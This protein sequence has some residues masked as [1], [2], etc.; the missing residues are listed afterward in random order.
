MLEYGFYNMDC[1]EGMKEFP[2]KFFDL[3][4]VDPPYGINVGNSSMGA[5]GGVAPHRNRTTANLRSGRRKQNIYT[6]RRQ[7]EQGGYK[8]AERNPSV[9]R[10][11][12]DSL[13]H[14]KFTRHSMTATHRMSNISKN[15]HEWQRKQSFGA[16]TIFSTISVLLSV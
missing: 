9:I 10:V 15:Y 16:G 14:P 7:E 4:I 5:G 11:G 3:A 12:G 1:M 6:L 2:D 13:S 8:S